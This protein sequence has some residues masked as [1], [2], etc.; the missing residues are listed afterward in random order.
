M[1]GFRT[2]TAAFLRRLVL[3]RW[4]HSQRRTRPHVRHRR[5]H[6]VFQLQDGV[7]RPRVRRPRGLPTGFPYGGGRVL[8]RGRVC[9]TT[10]T[11]ELIKLKVNRSLETNRPQFTERSSAPWVYCPSFASASFNSPACVAGFT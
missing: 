9:V 3:L 11:E 8:E 4:T 6:D 1:G 2:I 5:L 10:K 7:R